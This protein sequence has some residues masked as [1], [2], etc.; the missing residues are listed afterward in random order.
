MPVAFALRAFALLL[1][2]L[3]LRIAATLKK[4]KSVAI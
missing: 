1:S 3:F 4:P 2:E